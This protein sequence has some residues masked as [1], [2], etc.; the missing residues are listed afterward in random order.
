MKDIHRRERRA[1]NHSRVR[2]LACAIPGDN[3][4]A[5]GRLGAEAIRPLCFLGTKKMSVSTQ[6]KMAERISRIREA[7]TTAAPNNR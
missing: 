3:V 5:G 1:Y 6:R 7:T 4:A 2:E